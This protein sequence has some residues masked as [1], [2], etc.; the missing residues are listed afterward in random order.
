MIR[1]YVRKSYPV[2]RVKSERRQ[3][4]IEVEFTLRSG[5]ITGVVGAS[6]SGKTTLLRTLAGLTRAN[7]GFLEVEG[8]TW[9]NSAMNISL[10]AQKRQVGLVFQDYVLFPNFTVRQNVLYAR[11]ER[12]DADRLLRLLGLSEHA[13][14]YPHEISG[15]QQQR[16][17]LARALA[18]KPLLLLLDEPFSALD[19]ALREQ[20]REAVRAAHTASGVTTLLV[21]H[22]R[23]DIERL[24][25]EVIEL[26]G[27]RAGGKDFGEE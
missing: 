16:T 9:F 7:E 23:V 13:D 3:F 18:R 2:R 17:A 19:E 6:G 4:G 25:D 27:G 15:G 20:A 14:H 8:S 21:S 24:C 22:D 26:D 1:F 11:N 5:S 10:P 12:E